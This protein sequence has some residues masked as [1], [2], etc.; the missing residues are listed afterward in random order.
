[1]S[2]S[3]AMNPRGTSVIE[4]EAGLSVSDVEVERT[5]ADLPQIQYASTENCASYFDCASERCRNT[6][7]RIRSSAF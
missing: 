3:T 2:I 7:A 1:M 4:E 6:I 5:H